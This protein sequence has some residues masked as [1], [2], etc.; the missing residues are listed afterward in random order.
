M[1]YS[2]PGCL[3][4]RGETAIRESHYCLTGLWGGPSITPLNVSEEMIL[5]RAGGGHTQVTS[6]VT[7][8]SRTLQVMILSNTWQCLL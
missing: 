5:G 2:W 7:I 4:T 3:D 6:I 1:Q 8:L